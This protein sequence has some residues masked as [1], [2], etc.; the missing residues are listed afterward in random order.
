MKEVEEIE[1]KIRELEKKILKERTK[2]ELEE[3]KIKRLKIE[4]K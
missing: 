1:T 2:E 4:I 3:F